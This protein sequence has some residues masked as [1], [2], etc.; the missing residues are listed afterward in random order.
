MS[1]KKGSSLAW[2]I[3]KV[4]LLVFLMAGLVVAYDISTYKSFETSIHGQV[5]T[6]TGLLPIA[7]KAGDRFLVYSARGY[8][9]AERNLPE[10]YNQTAVI[11]QPYL[12]LA[13]DALISGRNVV[14]DLY[15]N[16]ND[17]VREKT[18]VVVNA[19]NEYAPGLLDTIQKHSVNTWSTV[20]GFCV[21]YIDVG[22]DYLK[23]KVFVGQLS[24]ENLHKVTL[25]AFNTTQQYASQYYS[26]LYEK[27]DA[28]SK[29]K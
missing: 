13:S 11:A 4:F 6:K 16:V 23:T 12:K 24:P 5:L 2:K 9:W 25:E 15:G 20:S 14:V 18:P 10:Y 7:E 3:T 21:Q 29:L 28:Y 27:V 8:K 19:I 22:R 1:K 26:W 17:Y